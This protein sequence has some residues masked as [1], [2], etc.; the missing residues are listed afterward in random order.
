MFRGQEG[1]H[2]VWSMVVRRVVVIA[3]EDI[4][5]ERKSQHELARRH[6]D[7]VVVIHPEFH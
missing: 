2:P 3:V 6:P 7:A 5:V 1:G 4:P